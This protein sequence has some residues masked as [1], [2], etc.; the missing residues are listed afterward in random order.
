MNSVAQAFADP[1]VEYLGLAAPAHHPRLGAIRL[2]GQPVQFEGA[3]F[4]I[5]CTAPDSGQHTDEVLEAAGLDERELESLR[6]E[7]VIG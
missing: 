4:R 2:V 1:Q 7:G 6:R 5:V 3:P